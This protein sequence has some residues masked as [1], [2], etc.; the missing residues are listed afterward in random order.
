M[1]LMA[2]LLLVL[3]VAL[4]VVAATLALRLSRL[5]GDKRRQGPPSV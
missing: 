2:V 4:V 3:V 5:T 1:D